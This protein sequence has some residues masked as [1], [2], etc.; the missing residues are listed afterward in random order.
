MQLEDKLVEDRDAA[1]AESQQREDI[2]DRGE[3]T[4]PAPVTEALHDAALSHRG[5]LLGAV[6][7]I[8]D[9]QDLEVSQLRMPVRESQALD[10][11]QVAVDGTSSDLHQF[12]YASDR[13]DL[14][15]RALGVL[16]P[17]LT[18]ADDQTAR[19]LHAQFADL[20]ERVAELRH[21]LTELED[22]QDELQEHQQ[23]AGLEATDA[24]GDKPTPTPTPT[25]SVNR[26]TNASRTASRRFGSRSP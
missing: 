18:H 12:V 19:E 5:E 7:M 1:H 15:E 25:P 20:A 16:Q 10:A 24:P 2:L 11:L 17:N 9:G 6:R 4:L 8:L 3:D 22:A 23:K 13:R 21:Q 26:G 14:L